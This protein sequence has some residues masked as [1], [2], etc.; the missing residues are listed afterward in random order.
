MATRV[1]FFLIT[2]K[3]HCRWQFPGRADR[4]SKKKENGGDGA[5]TD[6]TANNDR[7]VRVSTR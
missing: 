3:G 7:P 1:E 6:P 4:S 5:Q 2:G